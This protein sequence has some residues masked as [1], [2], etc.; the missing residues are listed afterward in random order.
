MTLLPRTP[1]NGGGPSSLV[2][3]SLP[4]HS[5]SFEVGFSLSCRIRCFWLRPLWQPG[6]EG[7]TAGTMGSSHPLPPQCVCLG[8]ISQSRAAAFAADT[9]ATLGTGWL[10]TSLFDPSSSASFLMPPVSL[11]VGIRTARISV[12]ATKQL[13]SQLMPCVTL[14]AG[15]VCIMEGS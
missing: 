13:L 15:W 5:E 9:R 2:L 3:K 4:V 12:M 7:L 14:G 1:G 11:C 6:V 10:Q 8:W